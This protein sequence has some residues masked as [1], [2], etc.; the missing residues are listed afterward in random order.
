MKNRLSRT[1]L[2]IAAALPPLAAHA[3]EAKTPVAQYWLSVA[4]AKSGFPDIGAAMASEG[5]LMGSLIGGLMGNSA[6]PGSGS[7]AQK[8]LL[9]QLNSPRALPSDPQ[10]VHDIPR[11]MAMGDNLPLLPE[12]EEKTRPTPEKFTPQEHDSGEKPKGRMLIY[13]GCGDKVRSGQPRILDFARMSLADYGRAM[14]GRHGS[15]QNPPAPRRATSY[16]E[17]PNR[18]NDKK[19]PADASLLGEHLVHGNFTPD[20]RF[21]IDRQQDFMA[22]VE[23]SNGGGNLSGSVL[24][25]WKDIPTAIGS[26][27][28]ATGSTGKGDTII[29]TSS[30]AAEMG[31]GLM[32][33]LPTPDVRR[34]VKD[35]VLMAPGTTECAVPQGIFREAQGAMVQMIAY[36]EDLNT[37]WPLKPKKPEGAVKVRLKSTGSLM[38]AD[39]EERAGGRD[40]T[41]QSRGRS[42][43]AQPREKS[44]GEKALDAVKSIKGLFSF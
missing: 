3:A 16:A 15:A 39:R 44:E 4:T 12:K 31:W 22:P 7:G 27:V 40:Y 43:S 6:G 1:V 28:M 24:L 21:S 17:W 11:G 29:W 37:V 41:S 32:D 14:A 5:G 23:L 26:F 9:L 34:F 42:Y 13:W 38:L 25:R 35:K 18:E 10:T 8:T 36:G 2:A 30:N 20:I 33:Y 19:V